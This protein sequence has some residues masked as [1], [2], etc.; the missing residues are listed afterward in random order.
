MIFSNVKEW[1]IPEGEVIRV[2]DSLN[3]VIWEKISPKDTYFYV[4]NPN[5]SDMTM[6]FKRNHNYND[7]TDTNPSHNPTFNVYKSTDQTNWSLLTNNISA[8][9]NSFTVPA[10]GRVYIKATTSGYAGYDSDCQR[11]IWTVLNSVWDGH[12]STPIHFNVGGNIMSLLFGDSFKT[13]VWYNNT[14]AFKNF[15]C[16]SRVVSASGL[17]LA[18][19]NN[20]AYY[21][22]FEYMFRDCRQLT[23][24]PTALPATTLDG[25][26]YGGMFYGCTALTSAPEL[27]ATTLAD[28]CYRTMFYGCSLIDSITTYANNISASNC[29]NNWLGGVAATGDFYN[30]G[31]AVYIAGASGIPSGWTEHR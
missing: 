26:C 19:A 8:A 1:T 10:Y 12:S 22:V 28:Y 6:Q 16:Q 7:Q 2:T 9:G 27:P 31:T 13:A 24:A 4:E 11:D 18:D 25:Y 23:T 21:G 3:R 17:Y 14:N 5:D 29:L 15:F 30:L 20:S